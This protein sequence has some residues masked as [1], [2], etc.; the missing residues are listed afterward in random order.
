MQKRPTFRAKEEFREMMY[1][2]IQEAAAVPGEP[3]G[4]Y[5]STELTKEYPPS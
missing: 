4:Q 2:K 5:L 3:V 1:T